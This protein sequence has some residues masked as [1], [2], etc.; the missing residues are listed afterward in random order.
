MLLTRFLSEGQA[1]RPARRLAWPRQGSRP[2]GDG[3]R[4]QWPAML[5]LLL[6]LAV[7]LGATAHLVQRRNAA[8]ADATREVRSQALTLANWID[9]AFRS[10]E[11]MEIGIVDW[12]RAEDADSAE[13]LEGLATRRTHDLL[14]A[15]ITALPWVRRL[16]LTDAEGRT[17]A[18]TAA[19]PAPPIHA[20]GRDFIELLRQDP[21]RASVFSIPWRAQLDNQWY[22]Y[23]SRRINGRD[24]RLLGM[25]VAAID[26]THFERI[27]AGLQREPNSSIAFTRRDGVLLARHPR[28]EAAIGTSMA[29]STLFGP[30]RAGAEGTVD[31]GLSPIDNVDRIR[32]ARALRSQPTLVIATR[33]VEDVLA[34]W[35]EEAGRQMLAVLLVEAMILVGVL[36]GRRQSG[37]REAMRQL[38]Q[39]Q[40]EAEAR[41]ALSEE[42]ERAARAQ[43]GHEAALRAI[44]DNGAAGMTERDL[45][46]GRFLRVNRA[47]CAITG[48]SEAELLD[49]MS[50]LDIAYPED[51]A[52][53]LGPYA[54]AIAEAGTWEAEMRLLRK[55]GQTRWVRVSAG[56]TA[57]D[58]AGRPQ[59]TVT[60]MLDITESRRAG[61]RLRESEAM[62]RLGME[63]GH[64]GT[65][66]RDPATGNVLF[67]PEACALLGLPPD[68]EPVPLA[69]WLRLL[70]PEAAR[71]LMA[72]IAEAMA[73]RSTGA[74][75]KFRA[76]RPADGQWRHF[77]VRNRYDYGED[78]QMRRSLGVII[79]V[80][81]SREAEAR[82]AHLAHHDAL[83]GLPNRLLFRDRLEAALAQ[84]Q[85]GRGFTVFCLDLDRFKEVNDT[86]G[87]PLGDALLGAVAAR[88]AAG[89]RA[90]DTL[91]RLGGD[92]F[93]IIQADMDQ[94]GDASALA[95]RLIESLQ[96]PF[97]IEGHQVLIGTSIGIAI[98]P[99][100]G[101][102]GEALLKA[103][104]M[105]LYRAK[106][107]GRGRWRFFEAGM[108]A[109]MQQ[110]RAL[111]IDLRRAVQ[112]G[113]FELFYQPIV[114]I[115]SR[116]VTGLEALLRWRHPQRGLVPPDTFIPLAEETGLIVPLGDW[117]LRQ[118]CREAAGWAG[119]PKIAVNLSPAQFTGPQLLETIAGAL[120]ESGLDPARLEL[121]ITETAMLQDT[122]ATLATLHRMKALGVRIAMD[123][124]GTGYS[125]LS[126]LRRFPFDKVKI[127][128]SF[129]SEIGQSPQSAAIIGAVADLCSGLAMT[130]T[131][132]GVETEPQFQALLRM[133]CQEA[134]GY[135]F[136]RPLPA[137]EIPGLLRVLRA[138]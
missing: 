96:A 126:Y 73:R 14:S 55:D 70:E 38:S 40:L 22:V 59:R 93:A 2:A 115:P 26:L 15:R 81:E 53:I 16:F 7:L 49:G 95:G 68:P 65:F 33:A 110:R 47:F 108:D 19:F 24:G 109:R 62:L 124:F 120:Q 37:Q 30:L 121:E 21:G 57:R 48:F 79:D 3:P 43:A 136:S 75:F 72:E 56:V 83:T 84:A 103:A 29:A 82:I 58:A 36:M 99:A 77:E 92:E 23:L 11:L 25:V 74:T 94:P 44:F 45:P 104:D 8:L 20:G 135:L 134:Q 12:V 119:A 133:G 107:E 131:A 60:I 9:D 113:E 105:A 50:P 127:D 28:A 106:A 97:D 138:G 86:L 91:A 52:L 61:E 129:T 117:V 123:D 41:L 98:S 42:R 69:T 31:R 128:R 32:A 64:I 125:S 46:S 18:S 87:H 5:A 67:G 76:R 17:L 63:I 39:L 4:P 101:R 6:G 100:D 122:E 85:R 1:D 112:A 34:G 102:S 132:E 89:L 66:S 10:V 78:G 71:L 111:E 27:F 51:R 137:A 116:Q 118:A 114:A 13:A 80:T 35:R 90:T 54:A 88:L 130:T